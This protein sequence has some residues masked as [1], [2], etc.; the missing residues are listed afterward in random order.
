MVKL[1]LGID[2]WVIDPSELKRIR[3]FEELGSAS[4]ATSISSSD[5]D[6]LSNSL[7]GHHFM[8]DCDKGVMGGQNVAIKTLYGLKIKLKDFSLRK[9]LSNLREN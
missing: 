2:S 4:S 5:S 7:C 9:A 1:R 8:A 6:R 3:K